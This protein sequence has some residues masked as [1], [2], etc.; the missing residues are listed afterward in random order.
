MKIIVDG[1]NGLLGSDIAK[2]LSEKHEVIELKGHEDCDL[3]DYEQVKKKIE[4]IMPDVFIHCAGMKDVDDSE[5]NP[6]GAYAIN[7]LAP[8]NIALVTAKHNIKLFHISSGAVF[9]G[10]LGRPYTEYDRTNPVNTYGHSKL[11][12]ETEVKTYNKK[13]FIV[14]VPLL[15]GHNGR[16]SGNPVYKMIDRLNAGENDLPY[17]TDQLSNPTYCEDIGKAIEV[18]LDSEA[19]GTYNVCNSGEVSRYDYFKYIAEHL[20]YDGNRLKPVL[21]G[22]KFARREKSVILDGTFFEKTF[23]YKMRSWTEAMDENL[24]FIEK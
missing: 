13:S 6:I 3:T 21:M 20:G 17:T 12:A 11:L 14:R 4:E 16:R 24:K 15:F 2:V 19:Y 1:T 8:K 5:R 10:E 23:N 9:D 18:M 22:V 7:T